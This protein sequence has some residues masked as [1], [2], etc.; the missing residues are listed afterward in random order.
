MVFAY[1]KYSRPVRESTQTGYKTEQIRM[2]KIY[3]EERVDGD[4]YIYMQEHLDPSR[5]EF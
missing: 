4:A 3:G 5:A 2:R 1:E